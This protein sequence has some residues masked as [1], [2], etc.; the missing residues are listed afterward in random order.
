MSLSCSG[1][2]ST[3]QAFQQ[4]IQSVTSSVQLVF[5]RTACMFG[6][7]QHLTNSSADLLPLDTHAIVLQ[8]MSLID[9]L[10]MT[11]NY[12]DGTHAP[13]DAFIWIYIMNIQ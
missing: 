3:A 8:L 6:W 13:T 1:I 5:K 4:V 10:Q 12:Q 2:L 9:L 7:Q 11:C